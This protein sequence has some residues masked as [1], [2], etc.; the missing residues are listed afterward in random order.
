M[1][2][3]LF[4][5]SVGGAELQALRLAETLIRTGIDITVLTR[6]MPG[7]PAF[8]MIGA[9]PVCRGI[10]TLAWGKLFGISYFLSCLW[11]LLRDRN[12]YDIIHCHILQGLHC[13]AALVMKR[14]FKKK[15]IIKIAMA[16][17]ISDFAVLKNMLGGRALLN[18]LHAADCLVALCEQSRRE[19]A[20]EGFAAGRV[21]MIPNG[22]DTCLFRPAE[23]AAPDPGRI[24]FIGALDPRKNVP[25][26]LAAVKKARDAGLQVS[27]D[28]VGEGPERQALAGLASDLGIADRVR[29][30]GPSDNVAAHLRQARVFVLPSAYEG[31]PNVVLEAM[32]CG[33]PVI[34]TRVGGVPD[35]IEHGRSGLLVPAGDADAL[36][37]GIREV[38]T[39]RKLAHELG[40]HARAAAEERFCLAAVA[41]RY[42][43]LYE[44]LAA[45]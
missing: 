34:A 24:V 10:R 23:H 43:E 18:M 28:I 25:L 9:V 36:C 33:L 40:R 38:L 16:G 39:D 27:L 2:I 1:I 8:E 20:G 19:A 3:A 35:V 5:P 37:D 15:V 12:S 14:L 44:R 32:A 6:H 17:G 45:Q 26:L 7:L 30:L 29:F 21:A 13:L 42:R 41:G 22:V 4:H 11:W 31:L